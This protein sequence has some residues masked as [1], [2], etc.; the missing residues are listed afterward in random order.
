MTTQAG[1]GTSR[2]HNPHVAGH[3]AAEQALANAGLQ[4]PDFVF[5]FATVGYDQRSLL[6]AVR[7]ATGGAPLSGC[8]G[9]GTIDGD[10][11]DESNYSVVVMAI[12]SDELRWHNGLATGLSSD[13]RGVGQRVAQSLSSDLGADAVGLFVFPDGTTVNF[14]HFF[15]GLETNLPSDQFLPIWGGGAGDNLALVQTYQYC[16][17][18]VASDGVAYALLSGEAQASWDIGIGYVPIGGERTVTRSQGNVV[19][20]IDGKPVLEVL[21][22]YLP[23]RALVEDWRRYAISCVLCLR[24]PSYMKDEE[25][26]VRTILSV[27]ATDGSATV[28]TEV[29]EGTSVWMSSRDQEKVTAGLDQVAHHIKHELSGAQP[30]LVFHFDCCSRGKLMFR[31]QEKLQILRQFRQA[32]GPEVPWA[33]F[34][35]FGEIGPVGKHNFYHN[36]T[37]VVLALG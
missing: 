18:E 15:A 13:S 2:H 22:E 37:A 3:E 25:Y 9:E 23:D 1:V 31:D 24:A 30:K 14:D 29:P 34:H 28:Q 27:D 11:A 33:G 4:K 19:Y 36:Q 6:R 5:M 21:K 35:S 20:E 26:V 32:V 16:D 10:Y 8:S 17:D 12:S 7:E